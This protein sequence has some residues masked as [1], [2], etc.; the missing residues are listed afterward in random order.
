MAFP[1]A[2]PS[3]SDATPGNLALDTTGDIE[4]IELFSPVEPQEQG[5]TGYSTTTRAL[6]DSP[7]EL[8]GSFAG[9]AP[10]DRLTGSAPGPV[11][12][13]EIPTLSIAI[14]TD[15]PTARPAADWLEEAVED[16]AADDGIAMAPPDRQETSVD[17]GGQ[18]EPVPDPAPAEVKHSQWPLPEETVEPPA[19]PVRRGIITRVLVSVGALLGLTR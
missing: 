3:G 17:A 15:A 19:P 2:E 16:A 13:G 9:P 18:D 6:A 1:V 5:N 8:P 4:E 11:P 10:D 14:S 7:P 12:D